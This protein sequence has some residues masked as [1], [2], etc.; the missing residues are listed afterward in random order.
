MGYD[1]YR[2]NTGQGTSHQQLCAIWQQTLHRTRGCIEQRSA[3]AWVNTVAFR[4]IPSNI[5]DTQY[6]HC[7]ISGTCVHYT[8]QH[9]NTELGTSFRTHL[10]RNRLDQS[11]HQPLLANQSEYTSSHHTYQDQFAHAHDACGHA[12]DPSH[13]RKTAI[14]HTYNTRQHIAHQQYQH[15][16]HATSR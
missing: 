16:I 14:G 4:N 8:H 10:G 3:A 2:G 11:I 12:L 6:R 13:K 9:A 15:H 7:I 1:A 5:A